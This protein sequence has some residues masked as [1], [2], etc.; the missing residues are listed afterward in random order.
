MPLAVLT[1]IS[2][3]QEAPADDPPFEEAGPTARVWQTYIDES[4]K[5][6]AK[7]VANER[8][9]V[10]ILLV[11]VSASVQGYIVMLNLSVS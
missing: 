6:D 8:D 1:N 7:M 5:H 9:K 3:H 10:N 11:F 2:A 4:L